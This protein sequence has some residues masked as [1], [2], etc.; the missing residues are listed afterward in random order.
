MRKNTGTSVR[1]HKGLFLKKQPAC[2]VVQKKMNPL[3][4]PSASNQEIKKEKLKQVE[5]KFVIESVQWIVNV[6]FKVEYGKLV[7]TFEC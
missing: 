1:L 4:I 3:K 6:D 2:G 7:P 5:L